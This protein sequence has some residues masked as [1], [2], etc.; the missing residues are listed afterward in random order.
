MHGN[1]RLF[2]VKPG[3]FLGRAI[4]RYLQSWNGA[5]TPGL[6]DPPPVLG[7]P[8]TSEEVFILIISGNGIVL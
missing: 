1:F 8:G 3:E 6:Q 5:G 7:T 2:K 4:C